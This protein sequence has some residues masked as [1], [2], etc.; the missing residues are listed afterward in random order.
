MNKLFPLFITVLGVYIYACANQGRP[1]GGPKDTIPPTLL[2]TSPSPA[3]IN[4]TG[5]IFQFTFDERITAEKIKQKDRFGTA[6][7]Y[8]N[9]DIISY[10]WLWTIY[11]F[12]K[13]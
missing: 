7:F 13:N 12:S 4:F 9:S 6:I 5:K 3:S 1:T 11:N 8:D 2:E 10:Q